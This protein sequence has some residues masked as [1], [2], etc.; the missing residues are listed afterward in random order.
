MARVV[1]K[2]SS[3]VHRKVLE[4]IGEKYGVGIAVENIPTWRDAEKNKYFSAKAR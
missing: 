4:K 2:A 3:A 1:S